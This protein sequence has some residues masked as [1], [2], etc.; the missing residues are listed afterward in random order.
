MKFYYVFLFAAMVAI[1][2]EKCTAKYLLVDIGNGKESGKFGIS[3]YANNPFSSQSSICNFALKKFP[4]L[5]VSELSF[6]IY[7]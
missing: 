1:T 6:K 3:F 2:R 7:I 5:F 4:I